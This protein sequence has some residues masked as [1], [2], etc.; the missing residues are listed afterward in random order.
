MMAACDWETLSS[1]WMSETAIPSRRFM[2][3]RAMNTR[4]IRKNSLAARPASSFFTKLL[5]KS[6][7][8]ISM[9][10]TFTKEL[11]SLLKLSE[12][13]RRVWKTKQKEM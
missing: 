11:S 2:K 10:R 12:A 1:S 13:G 8:P 3:T 7:S 4:K 9:A 6:N 5:V